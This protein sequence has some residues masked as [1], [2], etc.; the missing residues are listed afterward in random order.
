[1]ASSISETTRRFFLSASVA[2]LALA[3]ADAASLR[4]RGGS[5]EDTIVDVHGSD[6]Y[7]FYDATD[8]VTLLGSDG[9]TSAAVNGDVYR[10]LAKTPAYPNGDPGVYK[11][12][13]NAAARPSRRATGYHG[14][15]PGLQFASGDYMRQAASVAPWTSGSIPSYCICFQTDAAD[16]AG[17]LISTLR[18]DF[19]QRSSLQIYTSGTKNGF[20]GGFGGTGLNGHA[21]GNPARPN[22]SVPAPDI[23]T[24]IRACV[25]FNENTSEIEIYEGT[26]AGFI[27][28]GRTPITVHPSAYSNPVYFWIADNLT[29][30]L[31]GMEQALIWYKRAADDGVA[32]TRRARTDAILRGMQGPALSIITDLKDGV[33]TGS[34]GLGSQTL[35]INSWAGANIA[36]GDQIIVSPTQTYTQRGPGGL[37]PELNAPNEVAILAISTAT[38]GTQIRAADTQKTY[39][40]KKPDEGVGYHRWSEALYY[41]R[42]ARPKHLV[43]TVTSISSATTGATVTIGLSLPAQ[44]PVAGASICIDNY[45]RIAAELAKGIS[46]KT[47]IIGQQGRFWIS[48]GLEIVAR[49]DWT[50]QGSLGQQNATILEL[51]RW[52]VNGVLH[53]GQSEG[54]TVRDLTLRGNIGAESMGVDMTVGFGGYG[55]KFESCKDPWVKD[56]T[57]ERVGWNAFGTLNNSKG[58]GNKQFGGPLLSKLDG[59]TRLS[60]L[61]EDCT[62]K[63]YEAEQRYINWKFNTVQTA[64]PAAPVEFFR[65]KAICTHLNKVFQAWNAQSARFIWPT[66]ENA[67]MSINSSSGV[68]V[69]EPVFLL[70]DQCRDISVDQP[71]TCRGESIINVNSNVNDTSQ[72][73][74]SSGAGCQVIRP[75]IIQEGWLDETGALLQA[76]TVSAPIQNGKRAFFAAE[77]NYIPGVKVDGSRKGLIAAPPAKLGIDRAATTGVAYKPYAPQNASAWGPQ[78]NFADSNDVAVDGLRFQVLTK[79]G[80]ETYTGQGV[81]AC[82]RWTNASPVTNCEVKNSILGMLAT[83]GDEGVVASAGGPMLTGLQTMSAYAAL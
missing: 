54:I 4:R 3:T 22:I 27:L 12:A 55:V 65:P 28:V 73:Q 49:K 2:I 82:I 43:A 80:S 39:T 58:G 50:L 31:A 17:A 45:P 11:E 21:A 13:P 16:A 67:M 70:K 6:L 26:P 15:R 19:Q 38:P 53:V 56:V 52:A 77:G 24:P 10:H 14:G 72:G 23:G 42:Y 63:S 69:Y 78:V 34:I 76:V 8:A 66:G 75:T 9:V 37:D 25:E 1:M 29:N 71:I 51:P 35:A 60:G 44:A 36:V 64:D 68:L 46:G 40:A 33:G 20:G 32:A 48:Q 57:V 83:S 5:G 41:T 30:P 18:G 74:L 47:V 61:F 7:A 81:A 79:P 59:V 62:F